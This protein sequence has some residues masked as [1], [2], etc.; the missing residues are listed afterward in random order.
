MD[1]ADGW[2]WPDAPCRR[3]RRQGKARGLGLGSGVQSPSCRARQLVAPWEWV[4][5]EGGQVGRLGI[6]W[7]H[8]DQSDAYVLTKACACL[9]KAS[10]VP[11]YPRTYFYP[12]VE[13]CIQV[14]DAVLQRNLTTR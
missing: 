13:G 10:R 9:R 7:G 11:K 6:R 5:W 1:E 4:R 8:L 3:G 2:D 12:N 14:D